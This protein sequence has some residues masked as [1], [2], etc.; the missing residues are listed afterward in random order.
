ML[1]KWL[2]MVSILW[3]ATAMAQWRITG[4]E[5]SAMPGMGLHQYSSDSLV[6]EKRREQRTISSSAHIPA[7]LHFQNNSRSSLYAGIGIRFDD[8]AMNKYNFADG[9]FSIF[10]IPFGGNPYFDTASISR[11]SFSTKSITLPLAYAYNLTKNKRQGVHFLLRALV[12][13]GIAV[14]RNA[15]VTAEQNLSSG[16]VLSPDDVRRIS[17]MYSG[18]ITNFSLFFAPEINLTTGNKNM[19]VGINLGLQPFAFDLVKPTGT[20]FKGNT[21]FRASFGLTYHWDR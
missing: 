19:P 13:P 15:E 10:I 2:L 5:L 4:V 8:F 18:A 14:S 6:F 11:I 12:I 7:M 9:F 3:S 17:D 21:Y 20:F 16:A 1:Q